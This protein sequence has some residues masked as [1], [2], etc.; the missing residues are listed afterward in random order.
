MGSSVHE[1][2][3]RGSPRELP[4]DGN[5]FEDALPASLE[6][7][8]ERENDFLSAVI[9]ETNPSQTQFKLSPTYTLYLAIRFRLS[10]VYRPDLSPSDRAHKLTTVANK[11]AQMIHQAIQDNRDNPAALA[12]WMANASEVL[13]FFKQDRDIHPFSMDSQEMLAEA[14]QMAFH[15]LVVCLEY[16]LQRTLS[17]FL[18]END[19]DG[20]VDDRARFNRNKPTMIDILDTL[21]SAMNLLRRCRVN[22]ALTIQLFSQLFH[23]I[24]MWVF[25]ILVTEKRLNL[26][27]RAWGVRLKRRLGRVEA[28]AQKQGLELA[29][30][31]HLCRIIQAAH[32]LQAP[33]SSPDDIANISSTCF[34]LNSL[35]LRELLERYI[36]EPNEPPIPHNL[37][38]RVV[39]VA[40]NMA[41]D[42]IRSDGRTVQLEEDQDLQLPF[43]LPEDGYSCDSIKGVPNG[44][45][46]FIEPLTR[47]GLCRMSNQPLASGFWTVYMSGD[48]PSQIIEE[49]LWEKGRIPEPQGGDMRLQGSIQGSLQSPKEPEVVNVTFNKVNGSMGLS[50]VAA[51]GDG[52]SDRGIYIKSVVPEGAAAIDGRLQAGDQLL[53]VDGKS[54]VGLTQ[55]KAADIMKHTGHSVTLKVAKQGAIYH[56]LAQLLSQPSPV[57]QRASPQKT[58]TT[59]SKQRPGE[60]GPP[61]Y[62]GMPE[63]DRRAAMQK[64]DSRSLPRDMRAPGLRGPDSRSSPALNTSSKRKTGRRSMARERRQTWHD[65]MVSES[66]PESERR[67]SATWDSGTFPRTRHNLKQQ[68]NAKSRLEIQKLK[69][70]FPIKLLKQKVEECELRDY[71]A[72]AVKLTPK[73]EYFGMKNY[74]RS[75]SDSSYFNRAFLYDYPKKVESPPL[76]VLVTALDQG[77]DDVFDGALSARSEPE[78]RTQSDSDIVVKTKARTMDDIVMNSIGSKSVK[79]GYKNGRKS[80]FV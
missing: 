2:F 69:D 46:E 3:S 67:H 26:C 41:D 56:G 24:N 47:Q 62:N 31:C 22:A 53:E 32:L 5:K 73:G 14:V 10:S 28:W 49:S 80:K 50:I 34:K 45:G 63:P 37:I 38:D 70:I 77:L 51:K 44:L 16:D 15:H 1:D 71:R 52:Q 68:P 60:E 6:F 11:I 19:D 36:N 48:E 75:A 12:F 27:T 9:L 25:N 17:A 29:A 23:F 54:L 59:P 8:D 79:R 65:G 18:D 20:V 72:K 76:H 66:G 30:D 35:Q 57:M 64:P 74:V 4:R 42:L 40:E 55:E 13:H 39:S 43:L 78:K 58:P 7:R 21:S 61:P 33:K